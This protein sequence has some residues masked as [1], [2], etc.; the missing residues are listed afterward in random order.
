MLTPSEHQYGLGWSLS[1][2]R[3][4]GPDQPR[5]RDGHA[6]VQSR[7]PRTKRQG[8]V[9]HLVGIRESKNAQK[10]VDSNPLHL[11]F[12]RLVSCAVGEELRLKSV[13]SLKSRK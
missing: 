2:A 3:R 12:P 1:D 4:R 6:D 13:S 5:D 7:E 10:G 9:Y 11:G 8:Q